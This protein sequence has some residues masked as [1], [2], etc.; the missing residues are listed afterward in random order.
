MHFVPRSHMWQAWKPVG[1]INFWV[2]QISGAWIQTW[3]LLYMCQNTHG[4]QNWITQ[5]KG[6]KPEE[7]AR[8]GWPTRQCCRQTELTT[9]N[10]T[11]WVEDGLVFSTV[12][13]HSQYYSRIGWKEFHR[14]Y[15]YGILG[16]N[17][18]GLLIKFNWR[19]TQIILGGTVAS[20]T[21]NWQ[22]GPREGW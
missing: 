16:K 18:I 12:L 21:G 1:V 22:A 17:V 10:L 8:Q 7:G 14:C 15:R 2:W 11:G 9:L 19:C 13:F 3:P 20:P 6:P 5:E 4:K